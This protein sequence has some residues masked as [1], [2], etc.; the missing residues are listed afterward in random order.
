MLLVKNDPN[1]HEQWPRALVPYE[2]IYGVK[3][4]VAL[5]RITNVKFK[6]CAAA[7]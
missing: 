4:P 3:E 6:T 1:Y 7:R 5:S 2:R